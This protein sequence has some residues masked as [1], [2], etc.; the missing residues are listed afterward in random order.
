M[1]AQVTGDG[2]VEP[3]EAVTDERGNVSFN[4]APSSDPLNELTASFADGTGAPVVVTALSDP[5]LT[6]DSVV[7]AAS[8]ANGITPGSL[9]TIF[10]ANL[11]AGATASA[12][13]QPLPFSLS[14]V[15][16]FVAN[17]AA[18]MVYVSDRQ[19]N[20]VVPENTPVGTVNLVVST[21]LALSATVPV[22]SIS[23][24]PGI[25]FNT[26]NG[27][28]AVLTAGTALTTEQRPVGTGDT[29]E[30]Y[31]TGLGAAAPDAEGFNR[32]VVTPEATVGGVPANVVYS[33]LDSRIRR[34]VSGERYHPAWRGERA[35]EPQAGHERSPKQRSEDSRS[36]IGG[37]RVG[38][39]TKCFG[40][41]LTRGILAPAGVWFDRSHRKVRRFLVG[42][43]PGGLSVG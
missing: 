35:A 19:I 31:C 12:T 18:E 1:R 2:T 39:A 43:C 30:V 28:G 10:G 32:T 41:L 23:P 21:P 7:N 15:Q 29:V 24:S 27:Y 6:P 26:A 14:D 4:W 25:F 13:G 20:F 37:R 5:Y 16:V 3:Q 42:G 11:A 8:Y 33:G 36:L 17:R 22:T 40:R 9:A 38:L 34:V